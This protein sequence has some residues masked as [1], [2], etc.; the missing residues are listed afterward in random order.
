METP[1]I[2]CYCNDFALITA[3]VIHKI[4][5]K[6]FGFV[7][8]RN[9]LSARNFQERG[10]LQIPWTSL[11]TLLCL[12]GHAGVNLNLLQVTFILLNSAVI[13]RRLSSK[14][15]DKLFLDQS[16]DPNRAVYG[17]I[18]GTV[19]TSKQPSPGHNLQVIGMLSKINRKKPILMLYFSVEA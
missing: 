9:K 18:Q 4:R 1:L 8:E 12:S 10:N 7:R 3:S 16:F 17:K 13:N 2:L 11:F 15:P 14:G 6:N 19:F 5:V